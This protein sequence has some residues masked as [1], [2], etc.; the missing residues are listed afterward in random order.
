M[1]RPSVLERLQQVQPRAELWWDSS[2]L[3]YD[4][5]RRRMIAKAP[6]PGEMDAWL[7]R[8]FNPDSPPQTNL[9][10]G[11]TTNPPLTLQ[12]HQGNPGTWTAW[13]DDRIRAALEADAEMVYWDTYKE[14]A[15][16]GADAFRPQFEAS[17]RTHGFVSGP[18]RSRARHDAE[19]MVAQGIELHALRPRTS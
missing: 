11:V 14:I 2:P 8:L 17:G 9:F 19:G 13:I 10:R 3:V 7:D 18:D 4:R 15:K 1:T 5:W 12:R 6:D 16:R